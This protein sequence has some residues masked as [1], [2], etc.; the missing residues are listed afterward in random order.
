MTSPEL[1]DGIPT[2][3]LRP[4][5]AAQAVGISERKLWELTNRKEIPHA[6]IGKCTVYPVRELTEWLASQCQAGK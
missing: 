3:G 1:S 4:K 5:A 6:K 2:I